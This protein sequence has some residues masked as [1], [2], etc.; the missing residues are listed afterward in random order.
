MDGGTGYNHPSGA[1]SATHYVPEHA[2]DHFTKTT[3]KAT[4]FSIG[5]TVPILNFSGSAQTGYTG[6]ASIRFGFGATEQLCG[7]L[8]VPA[9]TPGVMVAS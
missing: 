2:N 5:C 8:A 9:Q 1:P 7:V 3:T 4:K 6:T